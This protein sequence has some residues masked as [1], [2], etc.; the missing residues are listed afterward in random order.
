MERKDREEP[1]DGNQK[2]VTGVVIDVVIGAASVGSAREAVP[3][4]YI[5]PA[6]VQDH[7]R[8]MVN[9]RLVLGHTMDVPRETLT[10][11]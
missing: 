7:G 3:A 1:E 6:Y 10:A 8:A 5:V 2:L 4:A 9:R 11:Y